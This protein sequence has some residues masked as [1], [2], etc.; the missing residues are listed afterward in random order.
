MIA[1]SEQIIPMSKTKA[2][3]FLFHLLFV[4]V[5]ENWVSVTKQSFMKYMFSE[6]GYP[7]TLQWYL[8]VHINAPFVHLL[9][10]LNK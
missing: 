2:H 6:D 8:Y 10:G 5:S 3:A 9:V 4:S 7:F 1:V